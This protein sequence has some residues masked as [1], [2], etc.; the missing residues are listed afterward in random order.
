MSRAN[1]YYTLKNLTTLTLVWFYFCCECLISIPDEKPVYLDTILGTFHVTNRWSFWHQ[2]FL[3]FKSDK[4]AI[5]STG[6][7]ITFLFIKTMATWPFTNWFQNNWK[8]TS[9]NWT[10]W[11]QGWSIGHRHWRDTA[12]VCNLN[13]KLVA[14]FCWNSAGIATAILCTHLYMHF[15]ITSIF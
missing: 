3:A 15:R 1:V 12:I 7:S 2:S 5:A 11:V 10:N 13:A 4:S 6:K 8:F 9:P 14:H